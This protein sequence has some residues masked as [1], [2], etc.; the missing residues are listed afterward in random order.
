[1]V[2]NSGRL[3]GHWHTRTKT[4]HVAKLNQ[5]SPAPF[6]AAHPDDAQRL[7]LADG[8]EVQIASSRGSARTKLKFD[9]TVQPGTLFMPIHWG[10]SHDEDGCVNAVT[11]NACDPISH[12]PE[13]KFSAVRLEE[14]T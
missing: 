7:G 13:L 11:N 5:L 6:I 4:G 9:T 14:A 10:Q 1:M 8:D 12:E 3:A 2:L